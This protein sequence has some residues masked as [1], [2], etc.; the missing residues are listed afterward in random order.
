M[1]FYVVLTL[2]G[3]RRQVCVASER[4]VLRLMYWWS[5]WGLVFSAYSVSVSLNYRI[6][7]DVGFDGVFII[8]LVIQLGFFIDVVFFHGVH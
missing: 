4:C 3:F 5:V 6:K 7:D 1:K 8:Y 2:S